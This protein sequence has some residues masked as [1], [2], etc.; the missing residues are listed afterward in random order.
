MLM[1]YVHNW[2]SAD[3]GHDQID[4]LDFC[5]DLIKFLISFDENLISFD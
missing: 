5:F 1:R 2:V 3:A 4:T